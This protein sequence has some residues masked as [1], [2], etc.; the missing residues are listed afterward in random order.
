MKFEK[1]YKELVDDLQPSAD[2]KKALL[3]SKEERKMKFQKK[4]AIIVAAVACL[5]VGTTVFATGHIASYTSSSSPKDA[6][7]NYDDAV[8]KSEELG[9]GFTIPET[10]SNGYK[11]EN[12]NTMNVKGLDENGQVMV[13]SKDFTTDYTKAD[14]PKISLFVNELHEAP[15]ENYAIDNRTIG[16]IVVYFNQ[17]TYKFVPTNYKWTEEDDEAIKDPHYE[18]SW[19]TEELEIQSYNGVTFAK[20]GKYYN[21][22]AWDCDLTADE[23]YQMAEEIIENTNN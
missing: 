8:K 22:F 21:M 19:G 20:D 16:G 3:K 7:T 18:I 23:W 17:A 13:T 2:L 5:L 11:F 1:V 15:E 6:I 12:A 9:N 10:F 4:K 14:C